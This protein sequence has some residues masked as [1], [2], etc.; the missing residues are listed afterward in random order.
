M[1][2]KKET[3]DYQKADERNVSR[4]P[5]VKMEFKQR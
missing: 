5:L 3:R 1:L 4:I 2:K